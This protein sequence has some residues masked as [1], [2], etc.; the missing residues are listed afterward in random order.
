MKYYPISEDAAKRAKDANSFSDYVPGSATKSYQVMV[1]E[2]AVIAARQ[3]DKVDPM[4]HDKIDGLLDKYARELA[5]VIN[6]RNEIDA[7]VPS[8][9]IAGGSNFPVRKKE[10]QNAAR[11]RN[12][13]RYA[14]VQGI[15][16]RI[17]SV[18]LGG[19]MS[20]DKNALAKLRAKLEKLEKHQALMKAANAAIRMKDVEAGNAKLAELGFSGDEIRQLRE[21]D[22]CGRVGYPAYELQNNNANIHRVRDRIA[23][24]EKEAQRA[25][26]NADAEPVTGDGYKL[27]ENADIG[28]I[29]FLFDDKPDEDTRALL[30]SYGF[31]WSPSQGAWQRMLNDN[32]RY[33]AKKVRDELDAIPQF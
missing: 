25:A 11:E 7:R 29:Q 21:P 16:Q 14:E 4:Y 19:I 31:R 5:D 33:A 24:L 1:D 2:A 20:D 15:L 17:R 28:R 6:Q 9:L 13:E 22:Y 18:G 8:I 26:E 10:K 3:K 30:K 32:G 12:E 27:V 23:A